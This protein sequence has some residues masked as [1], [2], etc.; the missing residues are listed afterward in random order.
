[1]RAG[2]L[3]GRPAGDVDRPNERFRICADPTYRGAWDAA[4]DDAPRAGAGAFTARRTRFEAVG[5]T[6]AMRADI[7][8]A[9]SGRPWATVPLELARSCRRAT[10][11]LERRLQPTTML[12]RL[13]L[14]PALGLSMRT[15]H[16][17]AASLSAALVR[18]V[19]GPALAADTTSTARLSVEGKRLGA[20]QALRGYATLPTPVLWTRRGSANAAVTTTALFSVTP[21][22]GCSVDA[23]VTSRGVVT[24]APALA[25]VDEALGDSQLLHRGRRHRGAWAEGTVRDQGG[26]QQLTSVSAVQIAR[27]R[28]LQLRVV[29]TGGN[30]CSEFVFRTGAAAVG[31]ERIVKDASLHLRIVPAS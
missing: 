2:R 7:A 22:R 17:P 30:G 3:A 5:P 4:L 27:H 18:G 29:A 1:M 25:Q 31:A 26:R 19:T 11:Q 20:Q 15:P 28:Y 8:L 16:F 23:K 13:W 14:L 21:T 6:R 24:R 9:Y 12:S 10:Q